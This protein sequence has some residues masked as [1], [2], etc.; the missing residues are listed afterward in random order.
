MLAWYSIFSSCSSN[1]ANDVHDADDFGHIPFILA[2][3]N[4][5]ADVGDHM[6]D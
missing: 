4:H 3:A 1:N 2:D 6:G 5:F